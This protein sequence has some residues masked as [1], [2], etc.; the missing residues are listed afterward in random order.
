M[1]TIASIEA[2][3]K[4]KQERVREIT[5]KFGQGV[6]PSHVSA[7]LAVLNQYIRDAECC[8]DVLRLGPITAAAIHQR[9]L[10]EVYAWLNQNK[11]GS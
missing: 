5:S 7:D 9:P 10:D 2:S 1:E 3:I 4:H 6:R 11:K 8:A